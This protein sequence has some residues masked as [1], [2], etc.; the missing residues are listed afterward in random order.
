M[1][2]I[3]VFGLFIVALAE[4]SSADGKQK[5]RESK[6]SYNRSPRI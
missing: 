6:D 3:I 5:L 1:E 2:L 4:K